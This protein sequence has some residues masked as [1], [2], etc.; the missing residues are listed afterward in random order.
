MLPL[1]DCTLPPP[2]VVVAPTIPFIPEY[3]PYYPPFLS[4]PQHPAP[5]K[6][7]VVRTLNHFGMACQADSFRSVGSFNSE[8]R[9][10]FGSSRS[11]FGEGCCPPGQPCADRRNP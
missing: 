6:H 11:F 5:A 2:Y 3:H 9:W 10:L 1:Q 8:M 7:A 4:P